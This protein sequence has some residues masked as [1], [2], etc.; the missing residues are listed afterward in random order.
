MSD[1][2][3][4]GVHELLRARMRVICMRSAR[5][6]AGTNESGMQAVCTAGTESDSRM[7]TLLAAIL[8]NASCQLVFDRHH[9]TA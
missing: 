7:L 6:L 3:A 9:L 1:M 8:V 2:Y 4:G 5:A